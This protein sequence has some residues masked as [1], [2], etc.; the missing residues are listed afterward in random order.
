M[1]CLIVCNGENNDSLPENLIL[2][3]KQY[4]KVGFEVNF[5][6]YTPKT[7]MKYADTC[8]EVGC[9]MGKTSHLL[10]IRGCLLRRFA[11]SA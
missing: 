9:N 10:P 5:A 6:P 1:Q 7:E 3:K 11:R 2:N 4:S 8:N